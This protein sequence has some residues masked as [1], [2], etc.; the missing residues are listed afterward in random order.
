M[1]RRPL[2]LAFLLLL[3]FLA[4]PA[5]AADFPA[6]IEAGALTDP[7]L[8][9]SN[10]ERI[11][12]DGVGTSVINAVMTRIVKSPGV[13][14]FASIDS[15]VNA[16]ISCGIDPAMR[17]FAEPSS[18]DER[19]MPDDLDAYGAFFGALVGHL[20]GRVGRFGV[21]NEVISTTHWTDTPAGYF[22]L[23]RVAADATHAANPD[24]IIR[25]SVSSSGGFSIIEARKQWLAGDLEGALATIQ[26][27]QTNDLGGG[28]YLTSTSQLPAYLSNAKVMKMQEF[29]DQLVAHQDLID[30]LQLHYYGPASSIPATVAMVRADGFDMPIEIWELGRRY[31]DGR[32]FQ[33]HGHADE[34]TRLITTAIGEGAR[35]VVLQQYFDKPENEMY[36]LIDGDGNSR[37]ARFAVRNTLSMLRD[38]RSAERLRAGSGTDGYRFDRPGGW[39]R[40]LWAT[41]DELKPGKALGIRSTTVAVT[42]NQGGTTHLPVSS[43]TIGTSPQWFE[44]DMV[45]IWRQP[46]RR[47][48][49]ARVKA[50]CPV[51]SPTRY[52]QG[53]IKLW[54]GKGNRTLVAAGKYR[55]GRGTT[56][57]T[58]IRRKRTRAKARVIF[59]TP[60]SCPGKLGN[61][62]SWQ[63]LP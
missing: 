11:R 29:Y 3:L 4:P 23:L 18:S 24:A 15:Q 61:C 51:A 33:Q 50:R 38:T 53:W 17:V 39:R 55:I 7:P 31:L 48:G 37:Q 54:G 52:C 30:A 9:A 20:K 43:V 5:R 44:P 19:G 21:E 32:P 60:F 62:R 35:Y 28:P 8:I 57:V 22:Q 46:A 14:D 56:R 36:G 47:K 2:P 25:D 40:V 6:G 16:A 1:V 13:Y 34:S 12:E 58:G 42:G 10:C 26:E 45:E 59:A 41:G 63:K 27:S 49:F